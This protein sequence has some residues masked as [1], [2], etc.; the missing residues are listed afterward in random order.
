M[1]LFENAGKQ[2]TEAV[3]R[4]ALERAIELSCPV[5]AAS[6]MGVTADVLLCTAGELGFR[7]RIVIVRGCSGKPRKGVNLMKPE[8][9]ADLE[10]RGAV[11]VTAAHALS[12]GERSLSTTFKGVYPLEIMA[13]TLRMFGQGT[14]V[15]VEASVMA[16]D[17]DVL[18]F[19]MPVVAMGGSHRGADTAIVLTPSYSA[20]VLDTV[21]HEVLCKPFDIRNPDPSMDFKSTTLKGGIST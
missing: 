20:S 15:C 14:K 10:E 17:A 6:T 2:N 9:K 19:G 18:P 13:N 1:I 12:A 8:V 4:I 3:A 5:V 7:G 11:I 21:V 16:M